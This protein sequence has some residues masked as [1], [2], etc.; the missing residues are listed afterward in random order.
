[1]HG[2]VHLCLLCFVCSVFADDTFTDD[3]ALLM[4]CCDVMCVVLFVLLL[5]LLCLAVAVFAVVVSAEI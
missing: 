4:L 2:T 1:M 5:C 3:V